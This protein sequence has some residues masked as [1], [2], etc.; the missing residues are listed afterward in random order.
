MADHGARNLILLSRSEANGHEAQ[1]LLQ[2]LRSQDVTVLTPRCDISD[3]AVLSRV[4]E[5]CSQVL[6]PIKG[7]I[8][9]T[10]VL[11]VCES[12]HRLDYIR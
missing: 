3:E 1:K 6:P 7:C 2:E 11:K 10:L 12:L 4:L 9:S 5:E 8:Q